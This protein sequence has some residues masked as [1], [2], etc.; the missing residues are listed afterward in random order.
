MRGFSFAAICIALAFF[1]SCGDSGNSGGG[2]IT[3]GTAYVTLPSINSVAAFRVDSSA[4][5][6][7]II[8]SPFT[9]GSSPTSV[10]V[11]PSTHFV[12]VVNRGS[13]NI[14]LFTPDT[15]T[16]TLTEVMP[17]TPTG[18]DPVSMIMDANGGFIYAVNQASN[19][20]SVYSVNS[21]SGALTEITGSPFATPLQPTALT[22]SRSGN[23]LY[24]AHP[25]LAAVSA[26][27]VASGVLQPVSGSP[28]SVAG[29]GPAAL[30]AG[31]SDHFLYV[32]N[33][34]SGN[35]SIMTI[36]GTTGALSE[37]VNSPI[38]AGT[39]PIFLTLSSSG[40]FLYSL[41][42]QSN[43]V[44]AYSADANT[45]ALNAL[46]GS[47]FSAGT[48]PVYS[49]IDSTSSTLFVVNQ[50]GSTISHFAIQTDGTLKSSSTTKA[51][52]SAPSSIAF[53]N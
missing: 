28:F 2:G 53:T 10:L 25:N 44:S 43:N 19:S 14:S 40:S 37:I 33:S 50:G 7:G 32:A 26:Y 18:V 1:V 20:I 9:A 13:N 3:T 51:T 42:L 41:N 49:V 46:T 52:G 31:A 12:Y 11:H 17:R 16:G 38:T 24:V 48:G 34:T 4:N 29:T 35:I 15:R 6:T 5:F 47:P 22:L 36:N 39:A 8:G 45:G 27:A 21:S 23:L 30:A